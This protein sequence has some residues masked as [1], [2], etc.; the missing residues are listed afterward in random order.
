M[1]NLYIPHNKVSL[2]TNATSTD[3]TE[4]T[5]SNYRWCHLADTSLELSYIMNLLY[6]QHYKLILLTQVCKLHY[7]TI[8]SNAQF[9]AYVAI[10]YATR[11]RES[12]LLERPSHQS[13]RSHHRDSPPGGKQIKNDVT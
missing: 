12:S 4:A 3:Q 2:F 5:S 8:P 13:S 11:S 7:N 1:D 9:M 10:A 6:T